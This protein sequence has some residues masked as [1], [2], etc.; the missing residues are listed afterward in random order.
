M[1]VFIIF[2]S[3]SSLLPVID[4]L[5]APGDRGKDFIRDGPEGFGERVDR[6]V[7]SENL[8]TV[9]CS[10]AVDVGDVNHARIHAYIPYSRAFH[11]S[12]KE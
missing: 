4:A 3:L 12:D 1:C 7:L 5:D 8:D 10:H 11:P 9:A 6:D 2:I